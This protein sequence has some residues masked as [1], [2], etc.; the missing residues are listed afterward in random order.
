VT[1]RLLLHLLLQMFHSKD[2]LDCTT[3]Q[4]MES[5]LALQISGEL[6][7]SF[8]NWLTHIL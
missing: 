5:L 7:V 2:L 3:L 8:A 6:K 1:E 4:I